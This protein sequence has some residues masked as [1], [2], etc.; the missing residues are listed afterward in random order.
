[1]VKIA[2]LVQNFTLKSTKEVYFLL[3]HTVAV[4]KYQICIKLESVMEYTQKMMKCKAR[5][6]PS[7]INV[8][9]G[10]KKCFV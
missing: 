4:L 8:E 9:I 2:F 6:R 7:L 5:G 1:M 10:K 3:G